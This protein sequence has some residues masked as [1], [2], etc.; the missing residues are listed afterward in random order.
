MK[1]DVIITLL[2]P[3]QLPTGTAAE[4]AE[5]A[6]KAAKA[7]LEFLSS[8]GPIGNFL[9]GAGSSEL[10]AMIEGMQ[11]IAVYPMLQVDAPANLG[12]G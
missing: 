7:L 8:A 4:V 2:I 6:T 10:W 12:M 5:S 9:F 11:L 3:R 1:E